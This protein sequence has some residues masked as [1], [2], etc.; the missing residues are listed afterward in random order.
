MKDYPFIAK[1]LKK[2]GITTPL[3]LQEQVLGIPNQIDNLIITAPQECG[4]KLTLIVLAIRRLAN[5]E[6]GNLIFI[7]HSKDLSQEL[8]SLLAVISRTPIVNL[9]MQKWQTNN[10]KSIIIG[11]P[12]QLSALPK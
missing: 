10:K 4:K 9:F 3:D 11:S 5:E 8:A 12:L 1:G 2:L 6:E 7:A